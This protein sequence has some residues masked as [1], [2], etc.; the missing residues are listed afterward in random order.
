MSAFFDSIILG[1]IEGLTEFIPVSS[2]GHLIL[3]SHV[4]DTAIHNIDSF[5]IAIQLGAILAVLT[6]Y[7]DFFK[8]LFNPKHWFSKEGKL[9]LIAIIPALL[10]G[11]FFY[12]FIKTHLFN[13]KTVTIGLI[14]GGII[15]ILTE[16]LKSK[17][18]TETTQIADISY[19][20]ALIIGVCQIFSLWPGT[21]RS[22]STIVGGLLAN[23]NHSTAASFSFIIAV[24]VMACAVGYDLLKSANTLS[25]LDI[26]HIIVGFIVSFIVGII[27]I[28]S[29]M[30]IL[31]KWTLVPFALYR[32]LL[33]T[34]IIIGA[35]Q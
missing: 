31:S 2:T 26:Q 29:F 6:L 35:V 13:T 28:R 15:M 9:I 23:L 10:S 17:K 7:F 25:L 8:P 21:S 22:G 27:A 32:I 5:N 20:Q 16:K 18:R 4:L 12:S 3:T 14:L 34:I 24:P 1:I 33:G 11:F 19:R 30:K